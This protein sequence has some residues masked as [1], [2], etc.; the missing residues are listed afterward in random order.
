[1]PTISCIIPV[2][3]QAEYL[4]EALDSVLRQTVA[5]TEIIVVDD[6]STDGIDVVL[7]PYRDQ[8]RVLRQSNRG[9]AVARNAGIRIATGEWLSFIDG[10]DLWDPTKL[11]RQLAAFATDPALDYCLTFTRHFWQPESADRER[12]LRALDH[13]ITRDGPGYTFQTLLVRAATFAR[14][15]A[16]DE[17]LRIGEDTDWFARAGAMGLRRRV[18]D[19]VLVNRR[20]HERNLSYGCL[21]AEGLA[22]RKRLLFA[23]IERTRRGAT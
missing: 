7:R 22:D 11:E 8:L 20:M 2:Y 13:P 4:G 19:D 14:V 9:A 10:D 6:G 12:E 23:H 17:A 18:M 21:T 3:N 15:G 16:L 1:M 5:P